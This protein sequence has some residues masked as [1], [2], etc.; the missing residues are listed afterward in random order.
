MLLVA[1]KKWRGNQ[2]PDSPG[3]LLQRATVKISY[4]RLAVRFIEKNYKIAQ[5]EY[6]LLGVELSSL[7]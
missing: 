2:T 3:A 6:W 1:E 5:Q 7:A 4:A